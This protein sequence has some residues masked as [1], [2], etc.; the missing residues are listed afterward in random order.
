M[1]AKKIAWDW[2]A[3]HEGV[4]IG[5]HDRIWEWAEVGL[6]EVK[7]SELLATTLSK[8]GFAVERGAAGMPT[9]FVASWGSGKPVIGVMGE[10]DAL[11]G[12]S[13]KA[14]PEREPLVAG[15]A[16]HG[17]GRDI[18]AASALGG[19]LAVK[20][21]MVRLGAGGTIKYFGCPA[22]ETLVG[23]VFMVRDGPFRS[24]RLPGTSPGSTNGVYLG[25]SNAMNS[26]K[27]EFFGV[28]SHAA[29]SPEAGRSALDAAELMNVGAN[30][31]REHIVQE[32]RVHYVIEDGG[33]EPNVVPPYARVWY[34]VRAPERDLVDQYYNWLLRIANG[35]DLMA[36]T[37][38][39][40]VF[41]TGVHNGVQNRVL[42]DLVTANMR[43][44]GAPEYTKEELA[45]ARKVGESVP[46]EQKI[47]RLRAGPL[48][49]WEELVEVDLN[50]R[51][52][53]PYAVDRKGGGSSDVAEVAWNLPTVEFG[54]AA[55]VTG[56][57]GHSW[58]V[59]AC[60]GTDIGRKSTLFASRVMAATVLELLT[61]PALTA[62]AWEEWRRQTKGIE[63]KSPLPTDLK[64]PLDQ[65]PSQQ[66]VMQISPSARPPLRRTS[67]E[68]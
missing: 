10:L 9:A 25:S 44:I 15:A 3:A 61:Q 35:A 53:N 66:P 37:T 33:H 5:A 57:P 28:A 29:G 30:Y 39:K 64:P 62:K 38:H 6:Q 40:V 48:P 27:F 68:R 50:R 54:T 20:E 49:D 58:Q 36:G 46:R 14:L 67:M 19:A 65:L 11:P 42:A 60:A 45:F 31:M 55:V 41:L 4:I 8:N 56:V 22:E 32:A 43:E 34:Y 23:K 63:Y 47:A 13:Q 59:A 1:T 16:G 24:G 26:V 12:I 52:Y 21:A 17:C 7:S 51:I 18:Y 2:I